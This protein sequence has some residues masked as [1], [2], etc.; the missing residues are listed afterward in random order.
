MK[1]QQ[2]AVRSSS[3]TLDGMLDAQQLTHTQRLRSYTPSAVECSFGFQESTE[4]CLLS[5]SLSLLQ[6]NLLHNSL[7]NF[8]EEQLSQTSS[9]STRV[10]QQ[11][12]RLTLSPL[13]LVPLVPSQ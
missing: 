7:R 10:Q 9:L 5:F 4:G 8:C 13:L 12:K 3:Q 1:L 2:T 11:Q 6:Q